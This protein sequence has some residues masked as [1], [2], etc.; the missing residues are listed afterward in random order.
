M[1][2]TLPFPPLSV[3]ASCPLGSFPL[4]PRHPVR[5]R[6]HFLPIPLAAT[7][8]RTPSPT[9]CTPGRLCVRR[10]PHFRPIPLAS[11]SSHTPLPALS[12]DT[13]CRE[14]S[15]N[16]AV[17]SAYAAA[18]C[19]HIVAVS[20]YAA[21]RTIVPF[22]LPPRRPVR[23]RQHYRPRPLA[24]RLRGG[25]GKVVRRM[26]GSGGDGLWGGGRGKGWKCRN[27]CLYLC[28]NTSL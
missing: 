1:C 4:P 7:S 18:D 8:S 6:P 14:V 22:R 16:V 10:S 13:A 17:D 26:K 21:A 27:N 9:L 12:A 23:R 5:C 24:G 3:A 25:E 19:V 2:F 20:T 28:I 15:Q 11:A